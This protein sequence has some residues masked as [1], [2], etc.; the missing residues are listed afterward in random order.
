MLV[1]LRVFVEKMKLRLWYDLTDDNPNKV[2]LCISLNETADKTE[3]KAM[4][5]IKNYVIVN[6]GV[7]D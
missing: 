7:K 2:L 4:L 6:D 5:L 3:S 1:V